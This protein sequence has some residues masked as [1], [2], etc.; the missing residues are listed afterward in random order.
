MVTP[1]D[2]HSGIEAD[3]QALIQGQLDSERA[4]IVADYLA[5]RPERAAE[6]LADARTTEGLRLALSTPADPP[7]TEL[8]SEAHQLQDRLWRRRIFRRIAPAAAALLLFAGGWTAHIAMQ[9][10]E[11]ADAHPLVETAL[12]AQ[13]ALELR[14]WMVSQPESTVLN[15]GE[16]VGA[17]G[18][19][20]PTLPDGWIVRD[21]QVVSSPERPGVAIA[22]D[23][24]K[25]GRV[26][27]FAIAQDQDS[28][29]AP[30][31]AFDYDGRSV[32]LFSNKHS[33]YVLVDN[34]G[35][36]EQVS[37]GASQLLSHLN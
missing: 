25:L 33:A 30:P 36:P 27:L 11:T 8:V 19:E 22:L 13:A 17:L 20:L 37:N 12:D 34:S 4:F 5:D 6:V 24:P 31:T 15:T 16:I 29:A 21:V 1:T 14:H 3:I 10:F 9:F 2:N 28:R 7:P 23:T 18:I 26:L 32:A 35:N